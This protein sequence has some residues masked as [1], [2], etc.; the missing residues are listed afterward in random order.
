MTPPNGVSHDLFNTLGR[1]FLKTI[2]DRHAAIVALLSLLPLS[3]IRLFY[4]GRGWD[5]EEAIRGIIAVLSLFGALTVLCIFLLTNPPAF[6]LLSDDSRFLVGLISFIIMGVAG[7]REIWNVFF[8]RVAIRPV[9]ATTNP[10]PPTS[11]PKP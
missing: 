5:T 8:A 3:L 11:P 1:D 6:D 10:V 7:V 4:A 2:D 9:N